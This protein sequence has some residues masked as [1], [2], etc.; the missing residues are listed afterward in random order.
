MR[1]PEFQAYVAPARL[2][3]QIW[4]LV[5]GV[6]LIVFVY[7]GFVGLVFWAGFAYATPFKFLSWANAVMTVQGAVP[8]LI[9]LFTFIGMALGPILAAPACHMRG[10]GTLF[11]PF[12]ITL[13]GFYTAVI[14]VFIIY[15]ITGLILAF[16]DPP[17]VNLPLK[18][19]LGYLPYAIP[20]ILIQTS[21]E[22]LVFRGYL[23][24]Q[25]AARFKSRILW[26]IL[27][28]ALFAA[29]HWDPQMGNMAWAVIA[30][31][32]AFALIA[33]DLTE[34][35]GSLGAAIGLHFANNIAAI[36]VVSVPETITGLALFVTP[37]TKT[38]VSPMALALGLNLIFLI[39]IWRTLRNI[40]DR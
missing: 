39:L 4:R 15:G 32:F 12:S 33:A 27:P 14:L 3:P 6:L 30:V 20:L 5:L 18:Q 36:L 16:I 8:T 19:W 34:K 28:S 22:E 31:T 38:D 40:L 26:M 25:L 24:Q 10:P 29:M 2:C 21:A 9:L 17:L 1:T 13:R 37:F 35:T 23:Q 11:G 7:A